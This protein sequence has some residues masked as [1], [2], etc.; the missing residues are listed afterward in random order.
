MPGRAREVVA[1]ASA[2]APPPASAPKR[3]PGM[4][5]WCSYMMP[6]QEA[7]AATLK[8]KPREEETLAA[9]Q[10]RQHRW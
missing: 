3:P 6:P 2:E 1:A 7:L 4:F 8:A 5:A 9:T 10:L